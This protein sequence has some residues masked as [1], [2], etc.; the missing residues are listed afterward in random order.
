MTRELLTPQFGDAAI[1][2]ISARACSL[3][4][5]PEAQYRLLSAAE[6]A[7]FQRG[8]YNVLAAMQSLGWRLTPPDER[9]IWLPR[10]T[11]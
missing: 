7:G 11:G 4:G 6:R 10:E 8:V 1:E 9:T 2:S 5:L 3:Q